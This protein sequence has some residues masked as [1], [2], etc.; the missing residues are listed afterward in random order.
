[1]RPAESAMAGRD[2][3]ASLP[4]LRCVLVFMVRDVVRENA[5]EPGDTEYDH[6]IEARMSDR[7]NEALSESASRGP[8]AVQQNGAV[9]VSANGGSGQV[10]TESRMADLRPGVARFDAIHK[11]PIGTWS[12]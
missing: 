11:V 10:R 12:V 9:V 1:M 7:A 6:V 8:F 5:L 3:G 2:V 4:R